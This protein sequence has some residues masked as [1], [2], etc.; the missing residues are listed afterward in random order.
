MLAEKD[1]TI[2]FRLQIEQLILGCIAVM[3]IQV[4]NIVID[5]FQ[6]NLNSRA[7]ILITQI[8]TL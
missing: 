4:K 1:R 2:D 8:S 5:L 3:G 6:F 7:E